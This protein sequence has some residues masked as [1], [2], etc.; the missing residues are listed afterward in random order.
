MSIVRARPRLGEIGLADD[1]SS[2]IRYILQSPC[3]APTA[4][5]PAHAS[6]S[7]SPDSSRSLCRCM[8]AAAL[9]RQPRPSLEAVQ[10]R[11]GLASVL[12]NSCE[13]AGGSRG[14]Q[15][16]KAGGS[17]SCRI[18]KGAKPADLPVVQS[19]K[20]ELGISHQIAGI[21][22][23]TSRSRARFKN[24]ASVGNITAFGYI[25]FCHKHDYRDAEAIGHRT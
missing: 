4:M 12:R 11:A 19:S 9:R 1:W 24:L 2:P 21:A 17:P 14:F 25:L 23:R 22:S 3:G 16:C 7:P 10:V 8:N 18:L 15:T 13:Y 6:Q 5:P 20:F